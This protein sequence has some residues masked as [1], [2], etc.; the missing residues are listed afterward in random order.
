MNAVDALSIPASE[1]EGHVPSGIVVWDISLRGRS[2]PDLL[3]L[4]SSTAF[5]AQ[6]PEPSSGPW[7]LFLSLLEL[8]VRG[9][10]LLEA[11]VS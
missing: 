6:K 4:S 2:A 11:T 1:G 5:T 7:L 10:L 9:C 8:M 3:L